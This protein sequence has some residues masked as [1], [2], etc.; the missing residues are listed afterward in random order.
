MCVCVPECR[1]VA[2]GM[3]GALGDC[4]KFGQRKQAGINGLDL[5][6]TQ[7]IPFCVSIVDIVCLDLL[8]WSSHFNDLSGAL[9][10]FFFKQLFKLFWQFF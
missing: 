2:C 4:A 5:R 3:H 7:Q 9:N 8:T 1:R 6:H 10:F